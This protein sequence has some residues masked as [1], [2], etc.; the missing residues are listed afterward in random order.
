MIA[1]CQARLTDSARAFLACAV[2]LMGVNVGSCF[3]GRDLDDRMSEGGS[4]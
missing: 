2:S 3:A 1:C 4:R